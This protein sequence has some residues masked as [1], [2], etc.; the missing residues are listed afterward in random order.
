MD[1]AGLVCQVV[2]RI[3]PGKVATYGQIARAADSLSTGARI[4][5]RM[6]GK[7]LHQNSDPESIPCHRVVSADG[8]LAASYAF[9]GA[10][11]QRKKLL[12]EGVIF[13]DGLR[14]DLRECLW[15]CGI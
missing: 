3:P 14:V 12:A 1:Y 15:E 9:G 5:P 6:V 4:T 8:K 7:A 13:K 10:A 2:R 11:A